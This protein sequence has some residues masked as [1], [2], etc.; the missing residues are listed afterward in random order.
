MGK[1]L[2][3]LIDFVTREKVTP[4]GFVFTGENPWEV[5]MD[6]TQGK[7]AINEEYFKSAPP[8]VS[9]YLPLMPVRDHG[10]F[11]SLKEGSTP[12]IKSKVIGPMLGIDLHFK[13]ESQ[14]PTGSFKAVSY[15]HLTLPTKRIV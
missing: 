10:Q 2:Y 6:L 8:Y 7:S 13:L 11:I 14:N 9:K 1:D 3:Q 5:V 15:T 12:L 4:E